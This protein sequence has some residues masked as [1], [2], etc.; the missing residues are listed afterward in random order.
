MVLTDIASSGKLEDDTQ[1][2]LETAV[3]DY[4]STFLATEGTELSTDSSI[5]DGEDVEVEQETIVT[6]KR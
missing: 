6:K 4:V 3:D 2:A 5:A 1:A